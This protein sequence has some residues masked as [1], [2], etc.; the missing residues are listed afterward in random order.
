[1]SER[2]N[3]MHTQKERATRGEITERLERAFDEPFWRGEDDYIYGDAAAYIRE[4][5][6]ALA[7]GVEH[8]ASQRTEIEK[9]R[10]MLGRPGMTAAEIE[11]EMGAPCEKCGYLSGGPKAFKSEYGNQF[12]GECG[13]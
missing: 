5:R 9:L 2:T 7:E 10:R 11:E 1:M 13:P 4:L 3:W 6:T 8:V 12:C